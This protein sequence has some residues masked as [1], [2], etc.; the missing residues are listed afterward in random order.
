[1][2]FW[3][4]SPSWYPGKC[5]PT[6]QPHSEWDGSA[7]DWHTAPEWWNCIRKRYLEAGGIWNN[8]PV[9]Q[10]CD[11]LLLCLHKTPSAFPAD[12]W[13]DNPTQRVHWQALR[14]KPR[15]Y[16]YSSHIRNVQNIQRNLPSHNDPYY[17]KRGW[18]NF[19]H[20]IPDK[21]SELRGFSGFLLQEKK[22][23][24]VALIS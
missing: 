8:T 16:F 23:C 12:K 4:S 18:Q 9:S 24:R 13:E 2:S 5:S 21:C 6:I 15:E 20:Y 14:K 11:F 3:D 22:T 17:A 1:M 10:H 19:H 7:Q